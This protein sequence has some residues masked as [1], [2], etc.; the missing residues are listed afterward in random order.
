M[1]PDV[2]GLLLTCAECLSEFIGELSDEFRSM[3]DWAQR[4]VADRTPFIASDENFAIVSHS[5]K[6]VSFKSRGFIYCA[7]LDRMQVV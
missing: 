6:R 7:N 4:L 2:R 3:P 1:T 5:E